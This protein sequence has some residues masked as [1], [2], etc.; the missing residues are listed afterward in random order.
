[1]TFVLFKMLYF[2]MVLIFC[3]NLFIFLSS[4]VVFI[5]TLNF[6]HFNYVLFRSY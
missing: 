1:M 4:L 2:S 5:Y 3:L 6:S